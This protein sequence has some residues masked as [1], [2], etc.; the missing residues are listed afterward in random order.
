MLMLD[1]LVPTPYCIIMRRFLKAPKTDKR[2][3]LELTLYW[4]IHGSY[5]LLA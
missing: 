3:S 2:V 1:M 5:T 4:Y